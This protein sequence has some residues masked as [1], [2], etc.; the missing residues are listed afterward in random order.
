MM[1]GSSYIHLYEA[2]DKLSQ[3]PTPE[4][5]PLYHA[6]EQVNVRYSDEEEIGKGGMKEV[7]RTYDAHTERHVALAR[8]KPALGPEH[9]DAFLREAHITGRLEHPNIIKLFDMGIDDEKRP[10][11]TMEF[12][13]GLSLRKILKALRGGEGEVDF[14]LERRLQ[15]FLRICEAMAYAHSRH[16]LHLDLKPENIQVG[17]FGEVQVCDWGMGEIERGETEE[18]LSEALLD[19]DLYG[20][21][22]EPSVKGTPGYMAPELENPGAAKSAQTDVFALGCLLYELSTLREP[23]DRHKSPPSSPAI[24]AV[25]SKACAEK[26]EER[27]PSVEQLRQD[28]NRHLTGYSPEVHNAGFHREVRLFYRRNRVP[29]LLTLIFTLLLFGAGVHFNQQLRESNRQTTAALG[30]AEKA[31][32]V[33]ERERASAQMAQTEAETTLQRYELEREYASVLLANREGTTLDRTLF[34]VHTLMMEESISLPVIENAIVEVDR[35]LENEPAPEDRLWSLKA[36]LLFMTQRFSE[37]EPFYAI[38]VGD[39]AYL[40]EQIPEFAP[41]V[42]ADGLLPI[43]DFVRLIRI[44]SKAPQDRQPLLEKMVIHDSLKRKSTSDTARLVEAL[45]RVSN[46]KWTQGVFEYNP[47]T[48]HLCITG[49]EFRSLYRRGGRRE[50]V[51]IPARSLLRLIPVDTLDLRGTRLYSFWH[52]NGLQLTEL[53]I[54]GHAPGISIF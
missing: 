4:L 54:R 8:P 13:R 44:L 22:L 51:T 46:P 12:K 45:L 18:Q 34:L 24:A 9:Y 49:N 11:F 1:P 15:I 20:D 10:F 14:P 42:G 39:Q 7:V 32:A 28:V 33:A 2:A 52:L 17:T 36:H 19:P 50:A 16:V 23:S 29:C 38:D 5:T 3:D 31:L 25:V 6:L 48:R 41:L 21:Q 47:K 35:E 37:A 40:R 53:D 30:Q 43:E 26:P 27:Y